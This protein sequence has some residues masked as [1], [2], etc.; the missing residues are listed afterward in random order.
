[1]SGGGPCSLSVLGITEHCLWIIADQ[2]EREFQRRSN[3]GFFYRRDSRRSGGLLP[4]R[5]QAIALSFDAIGKSA[6]W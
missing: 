6:S 5:P 3:R 2:L 1:M 4:G